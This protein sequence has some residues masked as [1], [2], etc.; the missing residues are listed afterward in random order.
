[1]LDKIKVTAPTIANDILTDSK[2]LFNY[3]IKRHLVNQNPAAAFDIKDAGGIETHRKRWLT[4][5]ELTAFFKAMRECRS[6]NT[7]HYQVIKLLLLFGNR[8]TELYKAKRSDFDLD[9]AIWN[10]S[11]E[12]KTETAIKIPIAESAMVI[13]KDIF[14]KQVDQSEYLFPALSVRKTKS[15]HINATYVNKLIKNKIIPLMGDVEN[16]TIHDFRHTMKSNMSELGVQHFISERC[17]NHKVSGMAGIYDNYDYLQERT[18]VMTL[19][20]NRVDACETGESLE[21]TNVIPFKKTA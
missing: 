13:L 5:V 2:Q 8:K 7:Q 20:A 18:R 15:G 14:S 6:V 11:A 17:L 10:L 19:W 3:A 4:T 1:M 12:N 21:I 16:F 9:Q